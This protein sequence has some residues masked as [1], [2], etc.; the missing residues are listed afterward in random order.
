MRKSRILALLR[1]L[2]GT[3]LPSTEVIPPP[4]SVSEPT[5]DT[6]SPPGTAENEFAVY[7]TVIGDP[8]L[9]RNR[10][11]RYAM[12]IMEKAEDKLRY[13]YVLAKHSWIETLALPPD[14]VT[15]LAA[16]KRPPLSLMPLAALE[17]YTIFPEPGETPFHVSEAMS[18]LLS[19]NPGRLILLARFSR[20]VFNQAMNMA[21][22]WFEGLGSMPL[23]AEGKLILLK[24]RACAWAICREDVR[25]VS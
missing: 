21:V 8:S 16:K 11:H 14:M 24:K 13:V 2:K 4:P 25:W 22:V 1:S 23:D 20:V 19:M 18:I 15:A 7:V 12:V 9:L 10:H 6:V 17:G 5:E 3:H